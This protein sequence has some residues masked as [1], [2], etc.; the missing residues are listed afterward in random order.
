ID[1]TA[2]SV[3]ITQTPSP[4]Q[5][6]SYKPSAVGETGSSSLLHGT[7]VDPGTYPSLVKRVQIRMSYLLGSTSYYWDGAE[8]SSWTVT[9]NTAWQTMNTP[10]ANWT[11]PINI[12]WPTD[13]SHAIA[14][15]VRGEDKST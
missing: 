14:L 3:T 5:G 2:P 6:G 15:E 7:D 12:A 13:M 9:T 10:P 4:A 1:K 8:F 11:Y